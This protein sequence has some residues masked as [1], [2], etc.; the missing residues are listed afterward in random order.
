KFLVKSIESLIKGDLLNASAVQSSAADGLVVT[1]DLL[2]AIESTLTARSSWGSFCSFTDNHIQ[3]HLGIASARCGFGT[4]RLNSLSYFNGW[5]GMR[6]YGK[7]YVTVSL[8]R[9][10]IIIVVFCIKFMVLNKNKSY[11]SL[12]IP[13]GI[14]SSREK[15]VSV[16]SKR[17][18]LSLKGV[19][20]GERDAFLS[21]DD[22][23]PP[24]IDNDIYDSEG[25]ILFLEEL[26]NDDLT[27]EIEQGQPLHDIM[28][29]LVLNYRRLIS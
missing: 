13:G 26:L 4:R 1:N 22:S 2:L 7:E 20:E 16:S 25:D 24:D 11:M 18:S 8:I 17:K 3:L 27:N 29:I 14:E 21:L 23:I 12:S 10:F 5:S 9:E 15:K 6:S 19:S 28:P